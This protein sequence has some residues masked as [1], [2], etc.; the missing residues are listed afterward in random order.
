MTA[1]ALRLIVL[2][3]VIELL[4]DT[5]SAFQLSGQKWPVPATY[6]LIDL[7]TPSGARVAPSGTSWN[8]AFQ[9]AMSEWSNRTNFHFFSLENSFADPCI[10]DG[11]NGVNFTL[12]VC[13]AAFGT[14]VIA[15]TLLSFT[16]DNVHVETDILFNGDETWDVF[17]GPPQLRVRE[18]GRTAVHELGHSVGLDHENTGSAIMV[19]ETGSLE[20]PQA[21]DINGTNAIYP[22]PGSNPAISL[23]YFPFDAGNE[24]EYREDGSGKYGYAIV[25][26]T[27]LV[28][29]TATAAQLDSEGGVDFHANDAG[30]LTLVREISFGST[31]TYDPPVRL[32]GPNLTIGATL[33]SAGTVTA[34]IPDSF[35]LSYDVTSRVEGLEDVVTPAGDF[36]AFK[37]SVSATF[38]GRLAGMPFNETVTTTVWLAR[39]VGV[40]KELQQSSDGSTRHELLSVSID[41][42]GD[43]YNVLVDNCPTVAN[44]DQDDSDGDGVGDPCDTGDNDSDGMS[45]DFELAHGL[46]PLDPRDAALDGDADGLTNLDE[47]RLRTDPNDPDTDDDGVNDGDEVAAGTDPKVH[48]N[49]PAVIQIINSILAE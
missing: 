43:G 26:G 40:V 42:D 2:M 19:P 21:D 9:Q 35:P 13:G 46:N 30:V 25:D 12:S 28:D 14:N 31:F 23:E 39:Y 8:D 36:L 18:F 48:A 29:V 32:L 24:W 11:K 20:V 44:P 6:F 15:V 27:Y 3:I 5:A 16:V 17:S 4:P 34:D 1:R 22:S 33:S 7:T 41:T 49:A 37:V 45:D 38:D 10:D 47:A